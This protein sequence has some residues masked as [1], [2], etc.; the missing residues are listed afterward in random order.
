MT[1]QN[2]AALAAYAALASIGRAVSAAAELPTDNWDAA[3]SAPKKGAWYRVTGKRGNAK[4]AFGLEGRCVY[5]GDVLN[6][7][8]T[9]TVGKRLGLVP[10]GS[11]TAVWVSAKQ[12]T[13][14][15][16]PV[17]ALQAAESARAERAATIL[18]RP[19]F[20]GNVKNKI[21]RTRGDLVIILEGPHRGVRGEVFWRGP[22]NKNPIRGEFRVGVK[23][24]DNETVWC[25]A[26]DVA[27]P[28][29]G[30]P[31][32]MNEIDRALMF[33]QAETML[34]LLDGMGFGA[35][36]IGWSHRALGLNSMT[37]STGTAVVL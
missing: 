13:R 25:S 8:N 14:I 12:C 5:V 31:L 32:P 36:A 3:W 15:L 4:H 26:R 35:E 24:V 37:F 11:E 1:T 27:G 30:Y 33:K 20:A 18:A 16:T 6:K 22:D 10:A 21:D 29:D 34:F 23:T 28:A 7:Y 2:E 19:A 17:A 9:F